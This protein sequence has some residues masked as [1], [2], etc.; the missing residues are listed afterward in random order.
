MKTVINLKKITDKS[1]CKVIAS[2]GDYL[3]KYFNTCMKN[4][5][6][7]QS[8]L[9]ITSDLEYHSELFKNLEMTKCGMYSTTAQGHKEE[10]GHG[11]GV[12]ATLA[13]QM[14]KHTFVSQNNCVCTEDIAITVLNAS[15]VGICIWDEYDLVI[16]DELHPL[17]DDTLACIEKARKEYVKERLQ[18]EV[19]CRGIVRICKKCA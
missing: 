9:L 14:A 12:Y 3:A 15:R 4:G 11:F 16:I 8:V 19:K 5:V 13:M 18:R 2:E 6:D 7:P 10:F 1:N 17:R